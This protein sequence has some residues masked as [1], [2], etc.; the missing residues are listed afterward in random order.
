MN[1]NF[2]TRSGPRKGLV[3]AVDGPAASGKGT[4]ARA[5][6]RHYDLPHMDTGVLYRSVAL[7]LARF[8]GDFDNE[9]EAVR[10]ACLKGRFGRGPL[11][12]LQ[13]EKVACARSLFSNG[14]QLASG[15]FNRGG[16]GTTRTQPRRPRAIRRV[17][18]REDRSAASR[19]RPSKGR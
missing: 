10:A 1:E 3:I 14:V 12:P 13:V 19:N 6:A 4:I 7:T 11:L 18:D 5:L 16:P 9:F 8:G 17:R 15:L 2:G